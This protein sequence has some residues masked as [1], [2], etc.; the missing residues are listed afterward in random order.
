MLDSRDTHET[1]RCLFVCCLQAKLS[2]MNPSW[3]FRIDQSSKCGR[4]RT[5]FGGAGHTKLVLQLRLA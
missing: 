5:R 2:E 3:A 1:E 4:L